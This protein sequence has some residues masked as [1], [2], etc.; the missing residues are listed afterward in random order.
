MQTRDTRA[1]NTRMLHVVIAGDVISLRP[2]PP[3]V[4]YY[5]Q[6]TVTGNAI[7]NT[8]ITG[9]ILRP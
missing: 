1:H 7:A 6:I 2:P 8:S 9:I 5:V 4:T 3:S